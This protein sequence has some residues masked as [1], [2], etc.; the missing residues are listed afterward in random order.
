MLWIVWFNTA[1]VHLYGKID[2]IV[3]GFETLTKYFNNVLIKLEPEL[4]YLSCNY[5]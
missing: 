3:C 5:R 2:T 1:M 4:V